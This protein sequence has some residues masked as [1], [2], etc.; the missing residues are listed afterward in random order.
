MSSFRYLCYREFKS[1]AGKVSAIHEVI[2]LAVREF[3][4]AARDSGDAEEY[5]KRTA[6][7][8]ALH[9]HFTQ[10][11]DIVAKTIQ[12]HIVNVHEAFERFLDAFRRECIATL[13]LDWK[14]YEK[15]STLYVILQ[16]IFGSQQSAREQIGVMAIDLCDYYRLVRNHVIHADLRTEDLEKEFRNV[17]KYQAKAAE[18]YAK[19]GLAPNRAAAVTRDDFHLFIRVA[20]DVAWRL[21]QKARPTDDQIMKVI[22]DKIRMFENRWPGDSDRVGRA[23]AV[24]IQKQYGLDRGEATRIAGMVH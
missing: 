1:H 16:N 19:L 10:L 17:E 18:T 13:D 5:L 3:E 22:S 24:L 23:V 9:V 4:N 7:R 8:H 6:D 21:C 15:R 12:L 11:P 2:E 14:D 20:Q